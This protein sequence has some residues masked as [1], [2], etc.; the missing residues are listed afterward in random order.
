MSHPRIMGVVNVTPD[1]FSDGGLWDTPAAAVAHGLQLKARGADVIDVG[2]ESTRPGAD[3]VD[4]ATELARVVPVVAELSAAGVIVSVDTTRASVAAESVMAG[5]SVVND[6]SGGLADPDML[7]AVAESQVT[8]IAMHWRGHSR[9]MQDHA[10][11]VDT[12]AEVVRELAERRDAALAAGI[13]ADRLVLD[14]G[15]GFSKTADHNWQ[16]LQNWS[17]LEQLGHP[18][19]LAA[20]RKRFLGALLG[21]DEALRPATERDVATAALAALLA[22][23]GLWG[24]RTHEVQA[25]AD[26]LAVAARMERP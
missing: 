16:L 4:E 9:T 25:T 2:G 12:V 13:A 21:S 1:S 3:R 10:S 20:S 15:L 24:V 17:V 14:P 7:T 18:L 19:L 6:V 23:R 5:A 8:Y 26:A 11:Y 22:A